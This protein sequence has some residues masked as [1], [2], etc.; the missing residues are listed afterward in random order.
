M[1]P[2]AIAKISRT[3]CSNTVVTKLHSVSYLHL[4]DTHGWGLIVSECDHADVTKLSHLIWLNQRVAIL[5][6]NG[7]QAT[8]KKKLPQKDPYIFVK[9]QNCKYENSLHMHMPLHL[10]EGAM[11]ILSNA[12]LIGNVV[13]LI[14]VSFCF[15][16]CLSYHGYLLFSFLLYIFQTLDFIQEVSQHLSDGI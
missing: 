10:F 2:K 1:H 3:K 5:T 4:A 14:F 12:P 16:H 6:L 15:P 8:F 9:N 11:L 7:C 13:A